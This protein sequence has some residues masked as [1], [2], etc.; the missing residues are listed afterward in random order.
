MR[1]KD[2][3]DM[4]S[5]SGSSIITGREYLDRSVTGVNVM[6][7]PDI[8]NWVRYGEFLITT[9]YSY[10]DNPEALAD[11]IPQLAE[12]G[13]A[14]V[15]IK[16]KRY[17]RDIPEV[18]IEAARKCKMVLIMLDE[19]VVFSAVAKEAMTEILSAEFYPLTIVQNKLN[20]LA[21]SLINGG[22]IRTFLRQVSSLLSNPIILLKENDENILCGITEEELY[23]LNID[24]DIN[25]YSTGYEE[26][27]I[28]IESEAK[29]YKVYV[30]SIDYQEDQ[31]AVLLVP[32]INK[33]FEE[34]DIYLLHQIPYMIGFELANENIRKKTEQRYAEQLI[35]DWILGNLD[36]S[37]SLYMRAEICGVKLDKQKKYRVVVFK[38]PEEAER[39][40]KQFT[41]RLRKNLRHN[42]DIFLTQIKDIPVAVITDENHEENLKW[43]IKEGIYILNG[44]YLY[45]CV[46][47]ASEKSYNLR[48]SYTEAMQVLKISNQKGY[49]NQINYYENMGIYELLYQ[50]PKN[51][52]LKK[53]L[54]RYLMPLIIYD[55]EHDG[56]LYETLLAYM[57]CKGNKKGTAEKLFTH[58]NTV[59]YRMERIKQILDLDIDQ[60]NVQFAIYLAV[61]LYEMYM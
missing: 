55:K 39:R 41:V 13:V 29:N 43:I 10:K 60:Y 7:V 46:G 12:R 6:E 16:I 57:E 40:T 2:L 50:L 49:K 61:L 47:A 45:L 1:V 8:L 53:Y 54:E 14:A 58:Y 28:T 27:Y 26:E 4:K 35:Q 36:S 38:L 23:G 11:L 19:K 52:K 31:I 48:E 34:A 32:E 42:S 30:Q 56:C 51:Q 25:N 24:D 22:E 44:Q 21:E 18:V 33:K 37:S 9:G 3:L 20:S 15:G 5:I 17:F 59:S